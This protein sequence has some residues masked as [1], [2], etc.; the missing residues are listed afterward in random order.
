MRFI[1]IFLLLYG[2]ACAGLKEEINNSFLWC[3]N[4]GNYTITYC[5]REQNGQTYLELLENDE[6]DC[7]DGQ[8]TYRTPEQECFNKFW[9]K[10][11]NILEKQC[12]N[13]NKR[14]ECFMFFEGTLHNGYGTFLTHD[15]NRWI[16]DKIHDFCSP[17]ECYEIAEKLGLDSDMAKPF[18]IK[19]C[20]NGIE[21]ACYVLGK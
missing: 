12:K 19:A 13:N 9:S 17:Q 7:Y 21:D 8:K 18:L 14:D 6:K 10:Y 11:G 5:E 1:C 2:Y 20:E 3:K 15:S 16:L 4:E